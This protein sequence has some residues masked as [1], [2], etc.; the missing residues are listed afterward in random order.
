MMKP[1]MVLVL[2]L[3]S[4]LALP[5]LLFP[6]A[7]FADAGGAARPATEA[8]SSSSLPAAIPLTRYQAMIEKSPFA[9]ATPVAPPPVEVPSFAKDFYVT[10][11]A[12]L[13]SK[14]F[15]TISSRDRQKTFALKEGESFEGM[16]LT[17]VEWAPE[18][19]RSK[20]TLKKGGD[21]GVI[22]FDQIAMQPITPPKPASGRDRRVPGVTVA[23]RTGTDRSS[24][25]NGRGSAAWQERRRAWMD[26]Y[27]N[28]QGASN[29]Q[30][31][32]LP[33]RHG[34]DGGEHHRRPAVIPA[35]PQQ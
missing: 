32:T 12:Q 34:R 3:V 30:G 10:G 27:R 35:V 19:G 25:D 8:A 24:D 21:S 1:P 23:G 20:V 7:L 14:P 16:T 15:V 28:R 17:K 9:P 29:A 6:A 13:G 5:L 31:G 26:A 2:V 11:I 22:T 18:V 4:V 33:Q